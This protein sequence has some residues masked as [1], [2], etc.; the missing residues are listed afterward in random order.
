MKAKER[1][2]LEPDDNNSRSNSIFGRRQWQC[3]HTHTPSRKLYEYKMASLNREIIVTS[4]NLR[5]ALKVSGK[6]HQGAF[7]NI[8]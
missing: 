1:A 6:E 5:L 4:E 8:L 2:K 7:L 3:T